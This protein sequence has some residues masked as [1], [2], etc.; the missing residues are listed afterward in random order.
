MWRRC[1]CIGELSFCHG[2]WRTSEGYGGRKQAREVG[3]DRRLTGRIEGV[4]EL[5][6]VS[7]SR[8]HSSTEQGRS[9]MSNSIVSS[10]S[11]RVESL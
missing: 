9:A 11:L 7:S 4:C 2:R 10:D 1:L 8:F 6:R 5:D 3:V